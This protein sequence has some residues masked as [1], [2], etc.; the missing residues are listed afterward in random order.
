MGQHVP[1]VML[2]KS[3]SSSEDSF[4]ISS[5][6]LGSSFLDKCSFFLVVFLY[7]SFISIAISNSFFC[8]FQLLLLFVEGV[9]LL[10]VCIP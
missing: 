2:Y 1:L 9:L 10:I 7:F 3:L 5:D 4:P 6:S 8:E